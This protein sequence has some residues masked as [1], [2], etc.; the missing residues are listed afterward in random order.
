MLQ[1][2][3]KKGHIQLQYMLRASSTAKTVVKA[4][5]RFRRTYREN[6]ARFSHGRRF[7]GSRNVQKCVTQIIYLGPLPTRR[8]SD[9]SFFC[10]TRSTSGL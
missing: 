10:L 8:P 6:R 5:S 7:F 1:P 4:T 2:L 3:E 9:E